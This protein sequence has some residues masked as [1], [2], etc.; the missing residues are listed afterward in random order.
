VPVPGGNE[1]RV[2]GSEHLITLSY[3]HAAAPASARGTR[4]RTSDGAGETVSRYTAFAASG[5]LSW[6]RASHAI[7]RAGALGHERKQG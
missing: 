1:E 6:S 5:C 3:A 7:C 4:T 2:S